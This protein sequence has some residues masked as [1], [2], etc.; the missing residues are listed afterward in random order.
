[1]YTNT[2][3]VYD[4]FSNVVIFAYT[5]QFCLNFVKEKH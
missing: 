5:I 1:M 4:A 3:L 2:V